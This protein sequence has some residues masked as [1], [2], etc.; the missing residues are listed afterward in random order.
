MEMNAFHLLPFCIYV[1]LCVCLCAAAPAPAAC[2]FFMAARF[3]TSVEA[4]SALHVQTFG[5]KAS[6]GSSVMR[7]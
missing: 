4:L 2:V 6:S 5:I 3:S 7:Y 1:R